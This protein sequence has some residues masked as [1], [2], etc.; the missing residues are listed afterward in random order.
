VKAYEWQ[1]KGEESLKKIKMTVIMP[2]VPWW[3]ES[4]CAKIRN[5]MQQHA[6]QHAHDNQP[7]DQAALSTIWMVQV[8]N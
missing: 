4:Q 6:K 3:L 2:L 5:N 7:H 1:K 8:D